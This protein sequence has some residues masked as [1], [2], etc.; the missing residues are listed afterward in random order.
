[1]SHFLGKL[2]GLSYEETWKWDLV[3]EST[4]PCWLA[5]FQTPSRKY[6]S[7]SLYP[8]HLVSVPISHFGVAIV[9]HAFS[10]II[11]WDMSRWFRNHRNWLV[12]EVRLQ[13]KKMEVEM[14]YWDG[15]RRNVDPPDS[16]SY[17][18]LANQ[19]FRKHLGI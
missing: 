1:M 18:E 15:H 9:C 11:S 4:A 2:E 12:R 8:P 17:C 7:T 19:A 5:T 14:N 3:W 16:A 10:L 6:Q 13:R